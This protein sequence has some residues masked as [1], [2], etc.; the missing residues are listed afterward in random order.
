MEGDPGLVAAKLDQ[1]FEDA[2]KI[3]R[4]ALSKGV[5]G[6][7]Y[8]IGGADATQ[9]TPM[10]YGGL[11]LERDREFL[12]A[13]KGTGAHIVY[14]GGAEP[15]LDFVS[16]L[17]A[18]AFAWDAVASG[19]AVSDVRPMRAGPLAAESDAADLFLKVSSRPRVASGQRVLN[20]A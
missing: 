3:A 9:C 5:L 13:L 2:M 19:I 15:Y 17:P 6:V 7:F 12:E 10:Q 16:D 4:A 11:Y 14:V 8:E 1:G 20:H 18:D